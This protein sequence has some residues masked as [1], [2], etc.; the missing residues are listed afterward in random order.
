MNIYCYVCS[1]AYGVMKQLLLCNNRRCVSLAVIPAITSFVVRDL[2]SQR[3]KGKECIVTMA[4]GGQASG[5]G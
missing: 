1:I 3:G 2:S 5:H 4:S